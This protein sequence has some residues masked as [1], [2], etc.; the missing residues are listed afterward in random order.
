MA[1]ADAPRCPDV[2][3]TVLFDDNVAEGVS[4]AADALLVLLAPIKCGAIDSAAAD[5]DEPNGREQETT[6]QAA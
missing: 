4:A 3:M 5:P 2:R 6:D 1:T